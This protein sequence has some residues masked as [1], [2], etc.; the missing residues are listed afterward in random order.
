MTQCGLPMS[1]ATTS[2]RSVSDPVYAGRRESEAG[3]CRRS[4]RRASTS[5]GTRPPGV[6]MLNREVSA[7]PV[8][9]SQR[10]KMRMPLPLFSASEPSGLKMRSPNAFDSASPNKHQQAVRAD[11]AV[12]SHTPP[13][14]PVLC[15]TAAR[16]GRTPGSRCPAR[17]SWSARVGPRVPLDGL[18]QT[19]ECALASTPH[20]NPLLGYRLVRERPRA[21]R[22]RGVVQHTVRAR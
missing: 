16:P 11:A 1:S 14:A 3:P 15:Q 21:A 10:A 4:P 9:T 18:K 17:G 20:P 8:E 13:R 19:T 2:S 5:T 22:V 7:R 6:R 12:A